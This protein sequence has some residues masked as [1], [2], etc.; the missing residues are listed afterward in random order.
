MDYENK[1]KFFQKIFGDYKFSFQT[2]EME[3]FCPFCCH[4]KKK[5]SIN[6]ET[7]YYKCWVCNKAGKDVGFLVRK[8]GSSY[9]VEIYNKNYNFKNFIEKDDIVDF[10]LSFPEFYSP[11][12]HCKDSFIGKKAYHYLL[13][14]RKITEDDILF[15]KLGICVDGPYKNRIIFPSFDK[16]GNLNFFTARSIGEGSYLLPQTPRGYKNNIVINELYIDWSQ[17][18][19]I[20]EGFIDSLKSTTKNIIPLFG[21]TLSKYSKLFRMIVANSTKICLALDA[22]AEEKSLQ[23]AKLLISYGNEVFFLD[24]KPF[25]DLGEMSKKDFAEKLDNISLLDHNFILRKK[26][27]MVC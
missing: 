4:R 24:T 18:L 8:F 27:Q 1:L 16:D 15:Y 23:I 3:V 14:Q 11:L 5:L 2:K 20:T 6:L 25:K 22:D 7:H 26:L 19:F 17:T 21:S 13:N 10:R 12:I 9:D